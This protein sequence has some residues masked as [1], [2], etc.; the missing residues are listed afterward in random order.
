MDFDFFQMI[1]KAVQRDYGFNVLVRIGNDEPSYVSKIRQGIVLYEPRKRKSMERL[2][3]NNIILHR[4][5]CSLRV[6]Q[7]SCLR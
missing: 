2:N 5:I 4:N 6:T 7:K 1:A 3:K